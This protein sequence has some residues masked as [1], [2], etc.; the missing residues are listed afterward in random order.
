M[1]RPV[2]ARRAVLAIHGCGHGCLVGQ[3]QVLLDRI[4]RNAL[5][6]LGAFRTLGA[7]NTLTVAVATAFTVGA[8]WARLRVGGV[9]AAAVLAFSAFR[10]ILAFRASALGAGFRLALAA[11]AVA[12]VC[13]PAFGTAFSTTFRRAFGAVAYAAS[14]VV[15]SAA[16]GAFAALATFS[17]VA[18]SFWR[19][20]GARRFGLAL[21][22]R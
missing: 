6:T 22:S 11:I 12:A 3:R 14:A 2:L 4:A 16:L 7:L 1:R 20:A 19:T 9:V 17:P 18:T 13:T 15:S 21:F 5:A 8:V 10:A